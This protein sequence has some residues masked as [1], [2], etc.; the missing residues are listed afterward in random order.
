MVF[1][2]RPHPR[3]P[4]PRSNK[5][6]HQVSDD[7]QSFDATWKWTSVPASVHSFPHIKLGSTS[8]PIKLRDISSLSVSAQWAMG[9][10][11]K[12]VGNLDKEGL[13]RLQATANVAYD[14]WAD[15]DPTKAAS[16]TTASIEIMIWLGSFG[17]AQ[18]LGFSNK[19]S[20]WRQ[21]LGGDHL[22]AI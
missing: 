22:Y 18:P 14:I 16:D 13:A 1:R 15:P 17:A 10:G 3:P 2:R 21:K 4:S 7:R 12:D 9:A 5:L 20:C 6:H 8:L 11:S 19:T